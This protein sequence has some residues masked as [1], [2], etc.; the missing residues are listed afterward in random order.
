MTLIT[1]YFGTYV[2][3]LVT[4]ANQGVDACP[5]GLRQRG[6]AITIEILN[7]KKKRNKHLQKRSTTCIHRSDLAFWA[8]FMKAGGSATMTCK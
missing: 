3:A 5:G 8:Y 7:N 4:V 2:V 6:Y 1:R